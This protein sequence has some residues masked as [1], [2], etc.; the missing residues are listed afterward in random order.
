[1]RLLKHL[2]GIASLDVD[3]SSE[4]V[5]AKMPL[6]KLGIYDLCIRRQS[7]DGYFDRIDN[8]EWAWD[9]KHAIS[10]AEQA[11]NDPDVSKSLTTAR[12]LALAPLHKRILGVVEQEVIR[13]LRRL[14]TCGEW[15]PQG[16]TTLSAA[17]LWKDAFV[18]SGLVSRPL[19]NWND[20]KASLTIQGSWLIE[21]NGTN[22]AVSL[23]NVLR[24]IFEQ[25][26]RD[27]QHLDEVGLIVKEQGVAGW[28]NFLEQLKSKSN[29]NLAMVLFAGRI[30]FEIRNFIE[31]GIDVPSSNGVI[32]FNEEYWHGRREGRSRNKGKKSKRSKRHPLHEWIQLE[33]K[34]EQ[35]EMADS[36][37]KL[38]PSTSSRL[39]LDERSLMC[40][41]KLVTV[42]IHGA[43]E[44]LAI[45]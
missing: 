16:G 44:H 9:W 5:K 11:L 12:A 32:V 42:V 43:M 21:A 8:Y 25:A 18:G 1:V 31:H 10:D 24:R 3:V 6:K 36:I 20:F 15:N 29:A 7:P 33:A 4:L 22:D 39:Y 35:W 34:E 23:A 40:C 28:G 19:E 45:S 38:L 26:V 41:A 14:A 2:T 17:T 13:C 30:A 27:H 37:P